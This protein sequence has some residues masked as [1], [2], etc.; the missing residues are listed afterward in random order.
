MSRQLELV[1]GVAQTPHANRGR[2]LEQML[3]R[4]HDYYE[5]QGIASIEKFPNAFVFCAEIE[6]QKIQ[7][8]A[9]KARTGDGKP[10]KREK[11]DCD[12]KGHARGFG[13]AF[14]A[15][16][17]AGPSIPLANFKPH[18][19][20][21]LYMFARTGGRAGFIIWAKR[22][23]SVFWIEAQAFSAIYHTGHLKS[24][25]LDWLREN[26]LTICQWTT[27]A[28]IDWAAVLFGKPAGL[29]A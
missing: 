3:A 21:R 7:T 28:L 5:R 2:A 12:F 29:S 27:A 8:P 9:L 17:F 26:A 24:L 10:L 11:T 15:K 18:Q 1:K 16:E 13:V 22:I 20:Q 14:D 23:D 4:T 25:N 19:V 6:W